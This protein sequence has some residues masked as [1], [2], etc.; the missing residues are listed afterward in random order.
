MALF[1][2]GSMSTLIL[3]MA[4]CNIFVAWIFPTAFIVAYRLIKGI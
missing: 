4:H 3:I 1:L 2:L